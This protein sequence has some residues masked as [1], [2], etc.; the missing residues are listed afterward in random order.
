MAVSVGKSRDRHG[1]ASL[2]LLWE[3]GELRGKS[4]PAALQAVFAGDSVTL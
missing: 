2:A 4:Q 3:C 1:A